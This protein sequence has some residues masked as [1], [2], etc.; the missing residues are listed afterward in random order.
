MPLAIAAFTT[1]EEAERATRALLDAGFDSSAL[2]ALA[3][4]GGGRHLLAGRVAVRPVGDPA[5]LVNRTQRAGAWAVAGALAGALL[6][7]VAVFLLPWLGYDP[8]AAV[9][10]PAYDSLL[11][12]AVVLLGAAL[13]A[14][15]GALFSQ[16]RGLPHDLAFRYSVRLDQ[17]DT[18]IAVATP[19]PRQ[20]RAAQE[21]LAM[22]GAIQAHV[23]RG[24]LEAVGEPEAPLPTDLAPSEN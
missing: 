4:V 19:S 8:L 17:G 10:P 23:T 22:N 3:R 21:T 9:R 20:A 6:A 5:L 16:S 13:A 14:G 15:L 11:S 1:L 12:V 2:T 7:A 24:T 18:V